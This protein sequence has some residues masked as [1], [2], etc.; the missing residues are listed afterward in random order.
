M[1]AFI[2]E[3]FT[4]IYAKILNEVDHLTSF[5]GQFCNVAEVVMIQMKI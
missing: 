2:N 5:F 4:Q 3:N 1:H